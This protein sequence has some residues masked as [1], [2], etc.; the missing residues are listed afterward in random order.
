MTHDFPRFA[1]GIDDMAQVPT[2]GRCRATAWLP[3]MPDNAR[4]Q[5]RQ[6]M[7][8]AVFQCDRSRYRGAR[9]LAQGANMPSEVM[10]LLGARMLRFL[11]PTEA[12]AARVG[13]A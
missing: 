1:R 13:S 8:H 11:T 2:L 4:Q 10:N 5:S 3:L 12:W 6:I 9:I 7:C